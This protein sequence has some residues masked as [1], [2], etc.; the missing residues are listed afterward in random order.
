MFIR[1][2]V[3]GN[4]EWLNYV[5]IDGT[6][7]NPWLKAG[8]HNMIFWWFSDDLLSGEVDD[9]CWKLEPDCRFELT[10]LIEYHVVMD[11]D[12][13]FLASDYDSIQSEDIKMF[14]Y[15]RLILEHI[16]FLFGSSSSS[17]E[18]SLLFNWKIK[19]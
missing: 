8:K 12:S 14:W 4:T 10:D 16:S 15:F 9:R 17:L 6:C 3:L 18:R 1:T 13:N 19:L 5:G 11:T 7:D 2:V